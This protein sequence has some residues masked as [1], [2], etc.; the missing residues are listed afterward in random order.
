M[1]ETA[2]RVP[3]KGLSSRLYLDLYL[4][5]LMATYGIE[6]VKLYCWDY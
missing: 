5:D 2:G 4:H 6:M 3:L 1:T